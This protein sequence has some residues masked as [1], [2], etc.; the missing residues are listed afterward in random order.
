[1]YAGLAIPFVIPYART[2]PLR[3]PRRN[4][5]IS[6]GDDVA[7]TVSLVDDDGTV[8]DVSNTALSL[9]VQREDAVSC[10]HD[11]GWAWRDGS[12]DCWDRALWR[13]VAVF[14]QAPITDE[15]GTPITD[16]NGNAMFGGTGTTSGV[17][18]IPSD[19]TG[20]W[21]GRHRFSLS[22]GSSTAGA[23]IASGVLDV[24]PSARP[25]LFAL[26]VIAPPAS[27]PTGT[28]PPNVPGASHILGQAALG[29]LYLG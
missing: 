4:L 9:S 29:Q 17:I 25:L 8:L 13:G 3:A 16:E 22:L 10:G 12:D 23:E 18:S 21:L 5:V 2:S 14:K 19:V 1:M 28:V 24:R 7:L 6:R 20:S 27:M 15:N 26:P 11:Y